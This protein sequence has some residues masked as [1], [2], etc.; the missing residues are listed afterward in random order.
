MELCYEYFGKGK[1]NHS[2]FGG[3]FTRLLMSM[4]CKKLQRVITV[5][6]NRGARETDA[7]RKRRSRSKQTTEQQKA[8]LM[9]NSERIK[10]GRENMTTEQREAELK[11]NQERIKLGRENMTTAQREAELGRNR[12]RKTAVRHNRTEAEMAADRRQD[13]ERKT[14]QRNEIRDAPPQMPNGFAEEVSF[15][16]LGMMDQL[17]ANCGAKHFS[18]ETS[19]SSNG[20][21]RP[22]HESSTFSNSEGK[23]YNQCCNHGNIPKS[24]VSWSEYPQKLQDLLMRNSSYI[25][26]QRTF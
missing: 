3:D 6:A 9:R 5:V 24:F 1:G 14:R 2:Q 25:D 18:A 12:E 26:L 19:R 22:V 17:C 23:T 21:F 13:K 4:P 7:Q 10:L 15:Y 16:R 8:E 20:K 11:S